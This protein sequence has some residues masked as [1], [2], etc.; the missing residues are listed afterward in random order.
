ML[1][2]WKR[3]WQEEIVT[4]S[5]IRAIDHSRRFNNCLNAGEYLSDERTRY[6]TML[7][8]QIDRANRQYLNALTALKQIKA[9]VIEMNIRTNT[10]FVSQNQQINVDNKINEIK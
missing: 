8:K 5:F 4:N 6:L 1:Q 3:L 10:A 9:P 2:V 7:S